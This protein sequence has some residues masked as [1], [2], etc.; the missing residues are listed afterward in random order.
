M[1]YDQNAL[2]LIRD[3]ADSAR[4]FGHSYVGS[5]HVLLALTRCPGMAGHLV[6]ASGLEES[7]IHCAMAVLYGV[8]TP[9]LPLPQGMTAQLRKILRSVFNALSE[10]GYNPIN[11]IVGYLLTEDPTYITNYNSA[12]SKICKIDRDELLQELVRCYL[13]ENN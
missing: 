1:N 8:G 3:A 12:R 2:D 6:R 5:A 7:L 9:D 11:Q 10:K 4:H 13:G